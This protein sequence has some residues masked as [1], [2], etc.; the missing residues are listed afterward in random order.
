MGKNITNSINLTKEINPIHLKF[1]LMEVS[2]IP[3]KYKKQMKNLRYN[4][5]NS[6]LIKVYKEDCKVL[7]QILSKK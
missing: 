3:R 1:N 2:H 6:M 7:Y 4:Q 5:L